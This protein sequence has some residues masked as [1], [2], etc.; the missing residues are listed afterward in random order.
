MT[1][2]TLAFQSRVVGVS[3]PLLVVVAIAGCGAG[4][5]NHDHARAIVRSIQTDGADQIQRATNGLGRSGTATI[6][7]A[8]CVQRGGSQRYSCIVDYTYGNSEGAYRYEVDVSATCDVRGACQ[9]HTD[10]AGTL[11]SAQPG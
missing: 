9:W 7:H 5:G 2:R 1:A 10:G 6:D 11:V 4:A 8:S 3:L